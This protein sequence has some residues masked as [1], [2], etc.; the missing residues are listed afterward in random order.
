MNMGEPFGGLIPGARGAVLAVLLRTGAPLT[1]RGVHSLVADSHSLG[2]VQQ[3][4]RDLDQL[5]VVL[6]EPVGRAGVHQINESHEAIESL[7]SLASPVSMLT[8]VVR[9]VVS[10]VDA[11]IL[12]GSV[13]RGESDIGSDIDLV[14]VAPSQWDGR[15]ELQRHVQERLGNGCDVMHLTRA[16]LELPPE[17]REPVVAEILRDGVWLLGTRSRRSRGAS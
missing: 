11:V 12:F 14:V 4:L 16:Q 10:G 6:T 15:A 13:A 1:G 17:Q 3:A 8:R 5:G 2:A 7:R 9:E